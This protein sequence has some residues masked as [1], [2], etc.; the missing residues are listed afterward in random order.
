MYT[1]ICHKA[2][3]KI[4]F[5]KSEIP[6]KH[7]VLRRLGVKRNTFA[8]DMIA[9]MYDYYF[10][11]AIDFVSTYE[12]YYSKEFD[13]AAQFIEEHF[14]ITPEKA[15][16]YAEHRYS[17]KDCSTQ[18]IER[19]IETLNYD[20]GFRKMFSDAVGGIEDEDPNGIYYE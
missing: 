11:G 16:Y 7:I 12:K 10:D 15:R 5:P 1:P 13:S 4:Y 8:G 3:G 14:N 2:F 19:H 6:K 18:S 17:M 9:R 20:E